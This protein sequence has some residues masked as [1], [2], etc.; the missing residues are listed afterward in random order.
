MEKDEGIRCQGQP[1]QG[2]PGTLPS[3]WW[4]MTE[5]RSLWLHNNKLTGTVPEFWAY[6]S[7]L[8]DVSLYG[9]KQLTGCIPGTWEAFVNIGQRIEV[10]GPY[11]GG[12]LLTAGTNI[13]RL[14]Y[15]EGN[16]TV[17]PK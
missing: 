14:V 6:L 15:C 13:T 9:N 8:R 4:N 2:Q 11:E 1:G 10:E 7:E 16:G 17:T 12:N 5:L 3:D